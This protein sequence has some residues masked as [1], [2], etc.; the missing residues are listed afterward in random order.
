MADDMNNE[1][2][3]DETA[4]LPDDLRRLLARAE[5]DGDAATYD[6]DAD[7][8]EEEEDDEELEESFGAVDRG[9]AA[10][11]DV[12]GGS[13]QISEF[14]RE[15]KQSFIEYSMS[16]ITARALPDVRD[17][18]K[19]V[20]RRIL[21]AMNESGIFP[22]RPHKK[23]AW[24]VGEVI[25][26]YH[27][28]GDSAVYDTMVRLAQWFSMRTPL[29]DG[30]GNFGNI[31]GDSAAAMRYTE[32]RLAKPAMEL[33]RDLQKDTVDWG[34]NYDESLAEPKV[35]P[36]RF[37]N[38]LVNGS[39]G[40]AVGMA[41]NIPPHNLSEVIE[42]TCML[43]DNP[44]ATCEELMTVLPGP[45]FP[46]GALI[47]GTSGIRQAYETGRGSITVRA[48]AHVESTKT[49][50]SRLVF[51]EIPY[52]VNKG[53]LQEKIAQLVNEKR[54]EGISDMR[55]ESTQ[56]G[57]RL[58]IELKKGV[59]PQVVLN[60]LYKYTSLQNTFGVNNLALVN[61]V[62]KCLSLR[63]ILSHYIDH[64]VDV[65][66]RR[67]RFDLKKAQ[68]RA[69][70]L[71][72]Y[73]MALDHIDEVISIIRS[74]QTDAEASSRLIERF[75]FSSEQTTAILEMKLRR[76]TGL[77]RDKIEDE[78]AGLRR[79]IAYYEDLLA[80][81]HKILGVIKEEMREISKKFGDKRRTEITRAER[82]LDV[83]D[84]IADED[85]VVTI[86]HTGYV[87]RIPVATYRSQ[88]RGGKGVSGVNLKED[89]VIAEMFIASTHEYVL[90]FSNKGKV[91]RLKVHELPVGSRQARGTA[92]VNL[93]PF[94]EGEKIASVIS[95]REFPDNEY[96]MF[97]TANGMVKKTVMSAYDRSRRDGIIAI[98]LKNGDRLLDVRR[99]REGDK[100]IMATTAG[101]A[102][103]FAED[104]VRAT[105]RDTSGVRGITMKDGTE[106][107]GMEISNGTGDLFVITERGYG[108]RTPVADYPEQNRGGQGVYT[109]QMTDHKGSLAAMKTVGPQ[110]ELFIITEGATV[111]RVKTEDVSQTGRATQGVKMMSVIDGDRVTA[112]ARMTSSEE[113]DKAPAE[114]DDQVDLDSSEADSEMPVSADERMDVDGGDGA[115]EDLLEE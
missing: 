92:I 103:V 25:G 115:P 50:R 37:P 112:V 98:N 106:V 41:T 9:E 57:I 3:G 64:Q 110:H 105:G 65:V 11:E 30:H 59:I 19:P 87:K 10:G 38:L 83:E 23:S 67:T 81:E 53:T 71:E 42:A 104:Q 108:K 90:F 91:Y 15:M 69:H 13:L 86:T 79:A 109:I 51:T 1:I 22:N 20:H 93:L 46:T 62:P 84:L 44:D 113:K 26:K 5:D 85:M 101:K 49:G 39:S 75:G 88:K 100:V 63:E 52:Q 6:P 66:T 45:D 31:D 77:E 33:L 72:G 80:N 24:T 82:D 7:S 29:I 14:G 43:I 89:D 16:V 4:G 18:L 99:V 58:V 36:A 114:A 107:L 55:D 74:S 94:E 56:K 35:L 76:L 34:P 2:G 28:H 95:C 102:I 17:G 27:P 12:N 73:L 96:L 111:I 78:L 48:K 60:N 40:I 8:D 70:I 97:A 61:G 47:M 54:I 21:Y 68:A 32:S